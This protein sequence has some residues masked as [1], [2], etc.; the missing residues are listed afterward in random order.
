MYIILLY[1]FAIAWIYLSKRVE[2]IFLSI[3]VYRTDI[4]LYSNRWIVYSNGHSHTLYHL[5][6]M[7]RNASRT[8]YSRLWKY[9]YILHTCLIP[10]QAFSIHKTEMLNNIEIHH[11]IVLGRKH[12]LSLYHAIR[13]NVMNGCVQMNNFSVFFSFRWI[14]FSRWKFYEQFSLWNFPHHF[15]PDLLFLLHST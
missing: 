14:L 12:F 11:A 1:V 8:Y 13:F 10:L 3:Y 5:N 7:F 2:N 9:I 4:S 6:C 15:Q